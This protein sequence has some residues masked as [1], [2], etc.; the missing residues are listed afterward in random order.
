RDDMPALGQPFDQR[1]AQD[2]EVGRLTG[3]QLVAHRANGGEGAVDR[4]AERGPQ[5]LDQR[6]RGAAGQDTQGRHWIV[7]PEI[8]TILAHLAMSFSRKS[9]KA[10]GV[11]VIGTAPCFAHASLTLGELTTL[12][13]SAF[14][15]LTISV[16]VP[17]GAM[18]PSQIVAS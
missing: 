12:V 9:P 11:M 14:S 1:A 8:F 5:A 13:I 15:L 2:H 6:L 7:A 18:M 3:Q 16:G 4:E 17:L 10:A